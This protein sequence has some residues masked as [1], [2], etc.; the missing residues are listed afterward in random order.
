MARQS[1]KKRCHDG[2]PREVID[3]IRTEYGADASMCIGDY[4]TKRKIIDRAKASNKETKEMDAGGAISDFFS[5][6][7]SKQ[8]T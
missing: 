6:S 4:H 3:S 7:I 2:T 8:F 5:K 1:L